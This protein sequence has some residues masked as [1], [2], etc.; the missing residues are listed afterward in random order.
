M[1]S[2]ILLLSGTIVSGQ[3]PKSGTYTYD[4]AF[5]EWGGKSLLNPIRATG[6]RDSDA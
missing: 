2:L 3:I 5:A 6:H 4:I 1:L